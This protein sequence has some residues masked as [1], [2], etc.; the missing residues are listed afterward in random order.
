[1]R[2]EPGPGK[3]ASLDAQGRYRLYNLPPGDYFVALSYGAS[4]FAVGSTGRDAPLGNLGSGALFYPANNQPQAFPVC[5]GEEFRNID[6]TLF[7]AQ[8]HA[9][10]GKIQNADPSSLGRY[11]L[12]LA[13][14]E[15]PGLAVAVA[16]AEADGAF[17]FRGV[18]A[19]AYHL[20]VSGPSRGRNMSG[21]MIEPNALFARTQIDLAGHDLENI[22][23]TPATGPTLS[24]TLKSP[25]QCPPK[26]AEFI[27][28]AAEDWSAHLSR[29]I[30]IS[31]G[32]DQA[33][34]NL[35]PARYRVSVAGLGDAC[36]VQDD[37]ELD[38]SAA[39]GTVRFEV[40]ILPV[41]AIYG[42][43]DTSGRPPS[44]FP[45]V[46]APVFAEPGAP[47]P[48]RPARCGLAIRLPGTPSRT[49]PHRRPAHGRGVALA[50]ARR[51]C[52]GIGNRRT[53]GR[54]CRPDSRRPAARRRATLTGASSV[55]KLV[56]LLLTLSLI[57][58]RPRRPP[59][60]S[61]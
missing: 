27:L 50:L 9:V 1:M 24:V 14:V 46:L 39:S 58:A 57:A 44:D 36:Y 25:P 54:A 40:P 42:R 19:G 56:L 28:T 23:L 21:A 47:R 26:P 31:A 5:G 18:P 43:I 3:F 45:I 15:Q 20:F 61:A 11:W 52:P 7:P 51:R 32:T 29:R 48:G 2:P 34:T 30:T 33:L 59:E 37:L 22:S 4:T 49:L 16:V 10:S 17:R 38:L 13:P 35:A 6:F 53:P 8:L 41:G 60:P 55:P 12:A